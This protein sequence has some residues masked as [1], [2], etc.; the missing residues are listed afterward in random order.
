MVVMLPFSGA[1]LSILCLDCTWITTER[2]RLVVHLLLAE[3]WS[4]TNGRNA[5]RVGVQA[6]ETVGRRRRANFE[7]RTS[8]K[9]NI[10]GN[11]IVNRLEFCLTD[12]KSTCGSGL[13]AAH[14]ATWLGA[15]SRRQIGEW[16]CTALPPCRPTGQTGCMHRRESEGAVT[17]RVTR[18]R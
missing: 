18:L 15:E 12:G 4:S 16:A 9:V 7:E 6:T 14:E 11:R 13:E 10:I 2:S 17:G 1:D 8:A 5:S 3:A